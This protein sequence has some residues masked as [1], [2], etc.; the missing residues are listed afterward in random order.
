MDTP[1]TVDLARIAFEAYQEGAFRRPPV[2]DMEAWMISDAPDR[3]LYIG[4]HRRRRTFDDLV[5]HVRNAWIDAV[6][7]VLKAA[8]VEEMESALIEER[9]EKFMRETVSSLRC[10]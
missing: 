9:F 4:T 10:H 7:A 3:H 2:V 5:P 8:R 6:E 1:R